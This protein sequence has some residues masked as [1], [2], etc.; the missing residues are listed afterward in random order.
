VSPSNPPIK[1]R[2]NSARSSRADGIPWR[3]FAGH[4]RRR[5]DFEVCNFAKRQLGSIISWIFPAWTITAK[6]ALDGHLSFARRGSGEELRLKT[7]VSEEKSSCQRF[8]GVAHSQL[9]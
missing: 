7:D 8:A 9:A 1:S 5:T 6:I 3:N 4:F 2:P